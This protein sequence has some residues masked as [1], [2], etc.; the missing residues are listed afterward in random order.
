VSAT[1]AG[2]DAGAGARAGA[3]ERGRVAQVS[4]SAGGAPKS[5]VPSARVTTLGL[6]G[7]RQAHP[8]IHGGPLRAVVLLARETIEALRAEGHPIAPGSTGENVTTEGVDLGALAPGDRLEIGAE[9]V[10]E[11][12]GVAEPCRQIA[13]SFAGGDF[14]R[15]GTARDPAA[16]RR[17]ARVVSEG[18]VAPGDAI[19]VVRRERPG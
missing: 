3:S 9:V 17:T 18:L 8:K 15:V 12:T 16:A 5:A 4:V 11:L 7:D 10:L 19:R 13:R 14:H 1:D 6:E 2:A